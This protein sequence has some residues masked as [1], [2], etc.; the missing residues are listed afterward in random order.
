MKKTFFILTLIGIFSVKCIN[1]NYDYYDDGSSNHPN[2]VNTDDS[3]H[4]II[5]NAG[6][7]WRCE[8]SITLRSSRAQH[9]IR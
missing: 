2:E 6:N 4:G 7:S 8:G 5:G 9:T 1:A 3:F